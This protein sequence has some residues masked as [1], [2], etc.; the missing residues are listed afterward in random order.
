MRQGRSFPSA[1]RRVPYV[2]DSR[3]PPRVGD[4]EAGFWPGIK[5][6]GFGEPSPARRWTPLPGRPVLLDATLEPAS[7]DFGDVGV[8]CLDRSAVGRRGVV[9]AVAAHRCC[10]SDVRTRAHPVQMAGFDPGDIGAGGG[11][12]SH[13]F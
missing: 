1:P 2:P 6:V 3:L 10:V 8:E 12:I 5:A 7:P 11:M 4:G 9:V 13:P